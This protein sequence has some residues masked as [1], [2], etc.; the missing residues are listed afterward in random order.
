M[1][2]ITFGTLLVFVVATRY[3]D[4][5]DARSYVIAA[6]LLLTLVAVVSAGASNTTLRCPDDPLEYCTYN[7]SEPI[8]LL[9][10][11]GYVV[12]AAIKSWI[13]YSER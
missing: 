6:P 7:D 4:R 11:I 8:V 2:S 12:L 9:V 13:M 5:S 3:G 1:V 10:W